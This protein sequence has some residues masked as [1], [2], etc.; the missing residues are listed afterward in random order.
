MFTLL[1][2]PV[3]LDSLR[4]CAT[5]F[6]AHPLRC[7]LVH[8][9]DLLRTVCDPWCCLGKGLS[10]CV[11]C[12]C[13]K[14]SQ[15]LDQSQVRWCK[16]CSHLC[17]CVIKA[18]HSLLLWIN[19]VVFISEKTTVCR[20]SGRCIWSPINRST[21]DTG[22]MTQ[23]I[24]DSQYSKLD[25]FASVLSNQQVLKEWYFR[26]LLGIAVCVRNVCMYLCG[27]NYE[28]IPWYGSINT[29]TS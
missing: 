28:Y 9:P 12:C 16:R 22:H 23:E 24:F 5:A 13:G 15:L 3:C 10:G 7:L 8:N 11:F 2:C 6:T 20:L 29:F 17:F 14:A 25:F 1:L 18:H 4:S 27:P 26:K 21:L 19:W